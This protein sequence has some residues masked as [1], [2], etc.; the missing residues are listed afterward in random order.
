MHRLNITKYALL[1]EE[2]CRTK[3]PN[4]YLASTFSTMKKWGI[5]CQGLYNYLHALQDF[6]EMKRINLETIMKIH[7]STRE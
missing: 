5:E 2:A 4:T 1:V 7:E 3:S 6:D